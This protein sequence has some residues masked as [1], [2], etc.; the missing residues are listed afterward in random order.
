MIRYLAIASALVIA[1][2]VIVTALQP[3]SGGDAARTRYATATGTPGPA[4]RDL[5][6]HPTPVAVQGEAP[7]ALSALPECFTQL[8]SRSG[9]AAYAR[10]RIP[11]D[12][13][14]V[15]GESTLHVVDCTLE[16]RSD[17]A[18]VERGE[19][20]LLIPG[21]ARFYVAGNRLI[22]D[23]AQARHEDVRVYALATGA[24]SFEPL[25]RETAP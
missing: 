9:P 17:W 6:A 16:V 21:I 15:S 23:R 7:W 11:R 24:P 2:L 5:D 1:F 20:R 14:R 3:K 4:Q 13:R 19:N 25:R 10:T 8:A 12:A 22:L 18:V